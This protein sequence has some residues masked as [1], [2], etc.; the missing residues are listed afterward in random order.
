MNCQRGGE[1]WAC[2]GLLH[3][4]RRFPSGFELFLS[5]G[6]FQMESAWSVRY[7][8]L[9]GVVPRCWAILS[10]SLTGE[11]DRSNRSDQGWSSCSVCEV[12]CMHS[13]KGSC[14]G[15]GEHACVQEGSLWFS[16][17]GLVV[18]TLCLSIVL[19]RMCWAVAL[20]QGIRD[21]SSS[22]DLA[23]CLFLASF[24]YSFLLFAFSLGL[25]CVCVVNALIKGEIEDHVWFEDQWMVA[26]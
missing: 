10:T 7:T 12:V 23:L 11:V 4:F 8:G 9:T 14:F 15:S 25:L 5:S 2:F 17:F 19:S 13:F 26:S 6:S 22:T 1:G 24:F 16:S 18:C 21:L 3:A 20:A